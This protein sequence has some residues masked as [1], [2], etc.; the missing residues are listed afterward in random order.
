MTG[1]PGNN[2][3]RDSTSLDSD[4]DRGVLPWPAEWAVVLKW[5]QA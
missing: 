4:R 3:P 1:S 5:W 2:K